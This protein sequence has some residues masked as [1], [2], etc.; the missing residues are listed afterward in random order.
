[1]IGLTGGLVAGTYRLDRINATGLHLLKINIGQTTN[2]RSGLK[3]TSVNTCMHKVIYIDKHNGVTLVEQETKPIRD[4]VACFTDEDD[5]I[6]EVYLDLASD[7]AIE[8]K[9]W[10]ERNPAQQQLFKQYY[11]QK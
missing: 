7:A 10:A 3:D 6:P 2:P 9:R 8:I 1:M 4:S 5:P 11:L